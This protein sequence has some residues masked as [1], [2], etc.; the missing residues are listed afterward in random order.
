MFAG[1][2]LASLSTFD[3]MWLPME[4]DYTTA[5]PTYGYDEGLSQPCLHLPLHTGRLSVHSLSWSCCNV[6][7]VPGSGS[8]AVAPRGS[9]NGAHD[10]QCIAQWLSQ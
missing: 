4:S 5:P 3:R 6:L 10:V 7:A 8:L 1:A 9:Q 2:V